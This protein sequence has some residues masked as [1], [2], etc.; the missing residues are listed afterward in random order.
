MAK[1]KKLSKGQQRR[2]AQNRQRKLDKAQQSESETNIQD[3]SLGGEQAGLV[4]RRYGQHADIEDSHG[5]LVR[6]DIR[7]TVQSLVCGDEVLWRES[8]ITSEGRRGVVEAVHPRRSA[9][10]RPDYYDGVKIVASNIDQIFV[11]SSILPEYTTQII[12]RYIIAAENIGIT[13]VLVLNKVDLATPEQLQQIRESLGYYQSLGYPVIELSCKTGEGTEQLHQQLNDHVNIF[14]GQSGVGK[15][16]LVN[17]L[18]PE[19]AEQVGDVSDNSGLGQHT[20]TA[21]KMLSLPSGGRLIDSPGV[22]EFGLWHMDP[23]H[24]T[25]GF[26]EFLPLISQCKFRDCKHGQDPGCA[27]RAAL[28]A[29]EIAAFRYENYHKI[30]E[31][32]EENRSNRTFIR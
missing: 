4:I 18:L 28:E 23:E 25:N 21:S 2:I 3:E 22:R 19:A 11:V 5:E 13:P 29:G 7:R 14:V 6:C 10:T 8:N 30:L 17:E 9:L 20:T 16:S 31:S 15:S 27:I 26:V 32:M 12:D 1:R 24:V